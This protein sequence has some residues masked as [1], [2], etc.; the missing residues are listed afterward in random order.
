MGEVAKVDAGGDGVDFS[1][2]AGNKT[3]FHRFVKI[4]LSFKVNVYAHNK[5]G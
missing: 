4:K 2:V 3:V 1:I 5:I